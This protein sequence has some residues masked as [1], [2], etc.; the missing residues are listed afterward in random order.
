MKR[1]VVILVVML[2][3]A[4]AVS[5]T[6]A[7]V[8][9]V[10]GDVEIRTESGTSSAAD[11]GDELETGDRVITGRT[12]EAELRL[13]GG[14]VVNIGPDT[15][16][17]IGSTIDRDGEPQSRLAAAVGSFLFRVS[18]VLGIEPRVGS[19][20]SVAGVR[21]TEVRV[22]VAS[23]GTT[24]YEVIEGLVD[25]EDPLRHVTLAAAQGV[26]ITPGVGAGNVFA[27]LDRPIDYGVWNAGLVEGFLANPVH[28]L[29]GIAAEM[30]DILDEIRRRGPQVETLL[31]RVREE[32]EKLAGIEA[33]QG[34]E[35]RQEY[36]QTTVMPMRL[37]ARSAYVYLRFVVLSALSLD[38]HILS[39]LAA[40]MEAAHFLDPQNNALVEF[41]RELA[42]IRTEYEEVAIPW[43]VPSDLP[44]R[45]Q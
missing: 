11:F 7:T 42:S 6:D 40:E 4:G 45:Q 31:E 19:T 25:I 28:T 36:F 17:L 27:F 9:Y 14:G 12:G 16:F 26:E 2:L 44:W 38:Q 37:R 13:A 39:R 35:A 3:G 10:E 1:G 29:R 24:R 34:L 43:L 30:Q 18:V 32:N 21:G 33:E 22:S 8:T 23:D 20:T 15:V 41:R 5:G